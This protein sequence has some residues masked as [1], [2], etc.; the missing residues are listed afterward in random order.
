MKSN[1]RVSAILVCGVLACTSPAFAG[2]LLGGGL[3]G[4]LG[5][6]LGGL[7]GAGGFG[8]G[9]TGGLSGMTDTT[10]SRIPHS[11]STHAHG[12]VSANGNASPA[13]GAAQSANGQA[14]SVANGVLERARKPEA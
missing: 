3:G 11:A 8:A 4:G 12:N 5:G 6:A 14:Q 7:G 9:G 13:T 10:G 2:G 1:L